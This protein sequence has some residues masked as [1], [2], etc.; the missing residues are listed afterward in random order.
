M[1]DSDFAFIDPVSVLYY[2]GQARYVHTE[3]IT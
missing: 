3:M 2:G 1:V